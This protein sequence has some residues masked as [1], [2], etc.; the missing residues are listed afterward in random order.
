MQLHPE[1]SRGSGA[2][3]HNVPA[4]I[5]D[6]NTTPGPARRE[7]GHH[8]SRP[9]TAHGCARGAELGS[10]HPRRGHRHRREGWGRHTRRHRRYLR[11]ALCRR[12][13]RRA[14]E[15]SKGDRQRCRGETARRHGAVRSGY[16][17]CR[18]E[19]AAVGH[20]GSGGPDPGQGDQRVADPR[21]RSRPV[22]PEGGGRARRRVSHGRQGREQPHHGPPDSDPG[23]CQ[24]AHQG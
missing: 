15:G 10:E 23:R 17:S 4:A 13:R 5:D 22:L 6:A 1:F 2:N 9:R 8:E 16:R 20:P 7:G 12:A 3:M 19:C 14:G 24:A 11:P 21:G 18:G